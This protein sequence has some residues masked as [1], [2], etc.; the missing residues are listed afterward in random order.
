MGYFMGGKIAF[1]RCG[2]TTKKLRYALFAYREP[3]V[4]SFY[5]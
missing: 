1:Y 3:M 2:R 5:A 4:R